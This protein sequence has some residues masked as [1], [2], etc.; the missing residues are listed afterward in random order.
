MINFHNINGDSNNPN[1]HQKFQPIWKKV[2]S[3]LSKQGFFSSLTLSTPKVSG[4]LIKVLSTTSNDCSIPLLIDSTTGNE[5]KDNGDK[6][7]LLNHTFVSHFNTEQ[8]PINLTDIP[9]VLIQMISV[10]A[11]LCSEEVYNLL[12]SLNA[13]KAMETMISQWSCSKTQLSVSLKQLL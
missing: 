1:D 3:K 13:T 7:E 8:I 12:R 10:T 11:F 4:K 5:V 2:V 6:A 9:S